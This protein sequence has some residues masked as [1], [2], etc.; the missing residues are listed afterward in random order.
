VTAAL[1]TIGCDRVAKHAA[2]VLLSGEPDRS[3]FADTVRL[4]YAENAGGFLSLGADWPRPVRTA[5]LTIGTG[6][7]LLGVLVIAFHGRVAGPASLGLALFVAGG[8]SNWIDRLLRGRVV[9]F[10]N[11]GIGPLRTGVFNMADLAI[12]VG[13]GLFVLGATR[14]DV[15]DP[16][17]ALDGRT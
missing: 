2:I 17:N 7:A 3:Y 9:D 1:V 11:V 10:L 16:A 6:L 8:A 4:E 15:A 12:M 13:A 5:V 14:R